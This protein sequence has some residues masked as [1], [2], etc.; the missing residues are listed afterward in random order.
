[1]ASPPLRHDFTNVRTPGPNEVSATEY[2]LNASRTD[3]AYDAAV[4]LAPVNV[5]TAF[6]AVGDGVTN[7]TAA[8]QAAINSGNP[9]Y[10]PPGLYLVT[11]LTIPDEVTPYQENTFIQGSG[12]DAALVFRTPNST[13]FHL[14]ATKNR[15][16]L[17]D[18]RLW[19]DTAATNSTLVDCDNTFHHVFD[20]VIFQGMHISASVSTFRTQIGVKLRNISGENRFADCDFNNLGVAV[21]TDTIMNLLVN[22]IFSYCWK[23]VQGGDPA[24]AAFDAGIAIVN[25]TFVGAASGT[26]STDTWIEVTGSANHWWV[27]NTWIEGCDK[28]IVLGSGTHGPNAFGMS[29]VKVAATTTCINIVAARQAYMANVYCAFDPGQT[30]TEVSINA[31]NAPDGFAANICSSQGYDILTSAFPSGWQ[32]FARGSGSQPSILG[33]ARI[34]EI[35]DNN[36][37]T[38]MDFGYVT[39][40][41]NHLRLWNS[42]AGNPPLL[43]VVG[44]STDIDIVCVPKGG[45][46]FR[47]YRGTG[48]TTAS[49]IAYG[50]ATDIDLNLQTQGTGQV[51]SNSVPVVTTTGTQT[52]TN[53]TLTTP[54]IDTIN[55]TSGNPVL[56]FGSNASAVNYLTVVNHSAGNPPQVIVDGASTDIDFVVVP[57]NAG[58]VAQYLGSGQTLGTYKVYGS[59]TDINMNLQSQGAGRVYE[60]GNLVASMVGVP[61]SHT[62][63]GKTG[64]VAGDGTATYFCYAPNLWSKVSATGWTISF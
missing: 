50:T 5:K 15:L 3:A 29:N 48:Q 26:R 56:H 22:C 61:A 57:K 59:A 41:V 8:I 1:M 36:N 9:V 23:G 10:I 20:H 31:T 58:S 17:K 24:G 44:A 45:G 53:K 51:M 6:G 38:L 55:D 27:E 47:I 42:S 40:A 52:Q 63:T 30:P 28:G 4:T 64:Q 21:R 60:N 19:L 35:R 11:A 32:Y 7:D 49:V 18:L 12:P 13:L 54:K 16:K 34:T 2:N 46:A 43:E 25:S 14:T 37:A 33:N 39:S 62:A